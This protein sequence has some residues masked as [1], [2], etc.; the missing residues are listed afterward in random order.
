M[1]T[2]PMASPSTTTQ[3]HRHARGGHAVFNSSVD[4]LLR[5]S[6]ASSTRRVCGTCGCRARHQ[7]RTLHTAER[8]C[9]RDAST[10]A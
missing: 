7:G 9:W 1:G 8:H 4:A 5:P 3:M 6:T 10:G 2:R